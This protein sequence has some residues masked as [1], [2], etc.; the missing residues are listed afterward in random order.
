MVT[1][2][3]NIVFNSSL[4]MSGD[5]RGVVVRTGDD[6][7]IGAIAG[8]AGACVADTAGRHCVPAPHRWL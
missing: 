3:R 6:T 2:A 1:E 5:G 8:L 4:V 7:Y